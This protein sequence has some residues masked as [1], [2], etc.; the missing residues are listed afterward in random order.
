MKT[1]YVVTGATGFVGGNLVPKLLVQGKTV[2]GYVRSKEKAGL[3]LKDTAAK[4]FFGDIRDAEAFEKVFDDPAAQYIVIHT[5]AVVLI[6]GNKKQYR[7]MY[8]VNINGVKTVI[9]ACLK[10]KAKLLHVS[11]VH[12]I[13]EPKKRATT[14]ETRRFDP[15]S[16]H[17]PYAKTKAEST[18]LV[19]EAV[20]S[21][22]L[23]AVIVHPSGITGPGDYGN[24]HMTQ[25]AA[26]YLA[27]KIPAAVNGGYDFVDVRDVCD[28]IIAAIKS[29]RSGE[30]YLL[31][32]KFYTVKEF[33]NLLS[34]L[35]GARKINMT[36]PMWTAKLGVPFIAL[37]AKLTGK[38]PLYTSYALY[39]LESN[40]NF[41]HE[42]ATRELGYRPMEL[43][44]SLK[45]AIEF[46]KTVGEK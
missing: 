29:F 21:A 22:G 8:D 3:V 4:L 17:G 26:D 41:S 34:E 37:A 10:H 28:G 23:K 27:G 14:Y 6:G 40:G 46:L 19:M 1:I 30:C 7:E 33:L 11:S 35:S 20:D 25:M 24:S 43:K 12:A 44:E 36:L 38:R 31:T 45:G 2:Y 32:N 9:A 15:K 16:V 18:A 39:T 42:K 5:A 13:A